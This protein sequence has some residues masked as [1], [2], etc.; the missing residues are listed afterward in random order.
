MSTPMRRTRSPCWARAAIGHA[1]AALPSSV[2]NSRRFTDSAS[3]ASDRTMAHL[4]TGGDCCAA[5][6]QSGLCR[7]RSDSVI[8]VMSAARP[9]FPRKRTSIRDLAMSHLCHERTHALQQARCIGWLFNHLVGTDEQRGREGDAQRPGGLE[10]EDEIELRR[11]LYR[12]L[13]RLR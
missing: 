3:R 13:A 6:F 10:V 8:P 11:L 12:K 1:V 7:F 4:S 2:M 5:G 9:L